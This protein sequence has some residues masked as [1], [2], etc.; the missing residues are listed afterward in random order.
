MDSFDFDVMGLSHAP[1]VPQCKPWV[2]GHRVVMPGSDVAVPAVF[3]QFALVDQGEFANAQQSQL[4]H[5]VGSQTADAHD[6]DTACGQPVLP[7]LAEE[8]DIR[9]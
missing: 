4:L 7:L 3:F 6:S 5:D 8:T 1:A 9:S 2:P